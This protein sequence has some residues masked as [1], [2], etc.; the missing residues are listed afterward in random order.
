MAC[1]K[2]RMINLVGIYGVHLLATLPTFYISLGLKDVEMLSNG[3]IFLLGLHI[4][5]FKILVLIHSTNT[6]L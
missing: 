6:E 5:G 2:N 4:D 1:H 3:F